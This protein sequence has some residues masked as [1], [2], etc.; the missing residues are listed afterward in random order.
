M[1]PLQCLA[2]TTGSDC[3]SHQRGQALKKWSRKKTVATRNEDLPFA[4][5]ENLLK[6]AKQSKHVAFAWGSQ[7]RSTTS[8]EAG[9][10]ALPLYNTVPFLPFCVSFAFF[11][12]SFEIVFFDFYSIHVFSVLSTYKLLSDLSYMFYASNLDRWRCLSSSSR[13]ASWKCPAWKHVKS[14]RRRKV[15]KSIFQK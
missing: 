3:G 7:A 14:P 2:G 15:D 13:S 1:S 4:K 5:L 12:R 9:Q 10:Y 6:S 11:H 8:G